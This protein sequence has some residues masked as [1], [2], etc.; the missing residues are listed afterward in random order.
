[1]GKDCFSCRN[2]LSNDGH[3]YVYGM[4]TE[5]Y[6][7]LRDYYLGKED[8]RNCSHYDPKYGE[9][10][11]DDSSSSG[12]C[13]MTSACV[14]FMGK[15]DDCVELNTLRKFRDEKLMK[16]LDGKLLVREYYHIAPKIVKA[17]DA[18]DKKDEYYQ[19]IYDTVLLCVD[20]INKNKD[21]DAKKLYWKMFNKYRIKFD[22]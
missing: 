1:M 15:E 10:D 8:A 12:G 11:D 9:D 3:C 21:E 2:M 16:D 18:S 7:T 14:D 20:K 22:L 4:V 19:D 6:G 17:I 5:N 13:F